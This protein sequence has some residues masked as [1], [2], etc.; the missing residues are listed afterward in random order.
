MTPDRIAA[1]MNRIK[2]VKE[3]FS[4]VNAL[5]HGQEES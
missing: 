5:L 3:L 2:V 1:N 4:V